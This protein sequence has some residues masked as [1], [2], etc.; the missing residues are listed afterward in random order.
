MQ[1][2]D[3]SELAWKLNWKFAWKSGWKLAWELAW[4]LARKLAWKLAWKLTWKLAWKL[5]W[6]SGWK[7]SWKLGWKLGGTTAVVAAA[8]AS[9]AAVA[10]AAASEPLVGAGEDDPDLAAAIALSL[11]ETF[12]GNSTSSINCKSSHPLPSKKVS[13]PSW[14]A[15]VATPSP[16]Q[17]NSV[18]R[19]FQFVFGVVGNQSRHPSPTHPSLEISLGISLGIS[20]EINLEITLEIRLEISL[21]ISVEG[22]GANLRGLGVEARGFSGYRGS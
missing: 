22:T 20:L 2:H 16:A 17:P 1:C 7:L 14:P 18:Q 8:P 19:H 12:G 11:Q 13:Q 4:K 3:Q 21:E 10:S 6:Q 5:A 15:P 9:A